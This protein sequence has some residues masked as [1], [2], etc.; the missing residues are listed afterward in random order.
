MHSDRRTLLVDGYQP[1]RREPGA[2][3]WPLPAAEAQPD[4]AARVTKLPKAVSAINIP[5]K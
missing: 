1:V 2:A 3:K 4:K 5:K